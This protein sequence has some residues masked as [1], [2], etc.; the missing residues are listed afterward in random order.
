M[1]I[2]QSTEFKIDLKTVIGI[3]MFTSSLVGMYYTLQDDIE[4]AKKMPKAVI[5][6]IEYDLKQD[7]HTDHINKLE[8]E[9]RELR[10]WCREIDAE[11]YKKKK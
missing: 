2:N 3:I 7:W 8:K 4:D 1:K 11:L 10:N 6:R 9:V 5:D